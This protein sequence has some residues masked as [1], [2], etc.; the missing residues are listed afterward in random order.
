MKRYNVRLL[1][2]L[3][4]F[5]TVIHAVDLRIGKGTM[6]MQMGV[7]N[8][9]EGSADLDITVLS[10]NE[11]HANLPL[12]DD[13]LY[14]FFNADIYQSD[15][16]DTMTY[17]A[18]LPATYQWPFIGQ[19]I[20]GMAEQYTK[21]PVPSDY[22]VRGFDLNLGVGY[23]LLKS[24]RGFIGVGVNTGIS[25][26]FF[27]VRNYS[28][29]LDF[30]YNILQETKIDI[31]TYKI[32]PSLQ[33]A[34]ALSGYLQIYGSGSVGY[35]TGKMENDFVNSSMTINGSYKTADIG[36]KL[37][38]TKAAK[39][40]ADM[41]FFARLGYVYKSWDID[42]M[43]MNLFKMLEV[44]TMGMYSMKFESRYPYIGLGFNF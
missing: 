7:M 39:D 44:N 5:T 29:G 33:M 2:L 28:E 13:R 21:L 15:T 20:S 24:N 11:Q 16:L 6:E 1:F 35:Q 41:T 22:E 8:F 17:Y 10:L 12:L 9:V 37:S 40:S 36:A 14:Y 18:S 38:F 34:Y 4:F 30:T 3:L 32:G 25:M 27:K 42:D 26:P 43:Q 31:M 23:D 19:S